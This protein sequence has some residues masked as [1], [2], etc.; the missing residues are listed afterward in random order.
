MRCGCA[1]PQE[2]LIKQVQDVRHTLHNSLTAKS[3][4][5]EIIGFCWHDNESN[6]CH[7]WFVSL[8]HIVQSSYD[9]V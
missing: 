4:D 2:K 8:K 1:L 9:S 3:I 7:I 5:I 6:H